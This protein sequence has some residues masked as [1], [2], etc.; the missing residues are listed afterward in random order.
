LL[1]RGAGILGAGERERG[2]E[3]ELESGRAGEGAAVNNKRTLK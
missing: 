3:G 2:R 1:A